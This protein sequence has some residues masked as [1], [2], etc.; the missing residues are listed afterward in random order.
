MMEGRTI[1]IVGTGNRLACPLGEGANVKRVA[2]WPYATMGDALDTEFDTV[3]VTMGKCPGRPF[4]KI[5]DDDWRQ[6]CDRVVLL[7]K[8]LARWVREALE[9][10]ERDG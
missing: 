9:M 10:A 6:V 4:T 7:S 5:K 3:V 8:S 1:L 2:D